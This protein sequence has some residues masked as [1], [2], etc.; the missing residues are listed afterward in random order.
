VKRIIGIT[1]F[2]LAALPLVLVMA[3]WVMW[4]DHTYT[5]GLSL[6]ADRVL[7]PLLVAD[8]VCLSVGLYLIAGK[9]S[10]RTN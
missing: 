4:I 1:L 8:I 9:S 5:L 7:A 2:V 6:R 10:S 3:G